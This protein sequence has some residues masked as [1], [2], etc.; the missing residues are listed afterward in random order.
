[1]ETEE[2]APL[3]FRISYVMFGIRF[4][5]EEYVCGDLSLQ[6]PDAIN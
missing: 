2:I 5:L 4:R 3:K 1:V 6:A